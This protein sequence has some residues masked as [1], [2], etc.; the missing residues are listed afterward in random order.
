MH[1]EM[2]WEFSI[3]AIFLRKEKLAFRVRAHIAPPSPFLTLHRE[4]KSFSWHLRASKRLVSLGTSCIE[5]P[6]GKKLRSRG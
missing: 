6:Y 3:V 1:L 2:L 5:T 4:K